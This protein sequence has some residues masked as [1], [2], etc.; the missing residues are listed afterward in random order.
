[1]TNP[2]H[3]LYGQSLQIRKVLKYEFGTEIVADHPQGG[4]IG[5]P[6]WATNFEPKDL[7]GIKRGKRPLFK[8]D[9]LLKLSR[10][11][12]DITQ[13]KPDSLLHGSDSIETGQDFNGRSKQP[14][15]SAS[16]TERKPKR[17]I[18]Q[19]NCKNDPQNNS[20]F[21]STRKPGRRES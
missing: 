11:L 2:I 3:P 12:K 1:V 18:H 21:S 7:S 14:H 8:I 20:A 6:V 19:N 16:C 10:K 13:S 15:K 5:L 4:F 9:R 17:S